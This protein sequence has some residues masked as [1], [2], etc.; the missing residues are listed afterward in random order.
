MSSI[1][2]P[3]QNH[4]IPCMEPYDKLGCHGIM[5]AIAGDCVHHG[6]LYGN[7]GSL[8]NPHLGTLQCSIQ[9]TGPYKLGK[10]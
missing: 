2:I 1:S 9:T 6:S 4:M 10:K 7:C 8:M 5:H 3:T